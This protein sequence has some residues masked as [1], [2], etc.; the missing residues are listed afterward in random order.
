M[1]LCGLTRASFVRGPVVAQRQRRGKDEGQMAVVPAT[2]IQVN[3]VE[4]RCKQR[5]L[6]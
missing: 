1:I 2:R 4:S 3:R 5:P 6:T